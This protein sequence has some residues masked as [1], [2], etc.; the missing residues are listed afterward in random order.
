M[1]HLTLSLFLWW[2]FALQPGPPVAASSVREAY[3]DLPGVRLC[4]RDTGGTGVPVVF[5]HAATGS[6]RVWEYQ[7]PGVHGGRLPRHRL[8][9]ARLRRDDDRAGRRPA[10]DGGR[11]ISRR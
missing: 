1:P 9:P 11:T 4:Y 7:I 10:R 8:R 6:S 3:A 5:L 2:A